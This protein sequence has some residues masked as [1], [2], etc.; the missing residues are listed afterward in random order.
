MVIVLI[1]QRE[2]LRKRVHMA[3]PNMCFAYINSMLERF[4]KNAKVPWEE[5][6]ES[7]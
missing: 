3:Q 4:N 5:K 7:N 2:S 6:V 1:L